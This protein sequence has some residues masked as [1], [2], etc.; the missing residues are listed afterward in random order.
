MGKL[1]AGA[2]ALAVL[3]AIIGAFATIPYLAAILLVLGGVAA[4]G[5]KPEDNLRVFLT[6]TVLIVGAKQLEALPAVGSYLAVIFANIGTGAFGASAVGVALTL[7]RITMA[8]FAGGAA[9]AAR[10][11]TA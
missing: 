9:P 10:P 11:A 1:F 2:R 4:I 3:A 6:A 7:W 8:A 5:N